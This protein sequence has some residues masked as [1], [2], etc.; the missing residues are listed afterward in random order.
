[1]Q[2]NGAHVLGRDP[3]REPQPGASLKARLA[4]AW[5][6]GEFA[7][8]YATID[9]EFRPMANQIL[10]REFELNDHD[11]EDCMHEALQGLVEMQD[12]GRRGSIPD[13][14]N[15]LFACIRNA[16]RDLLGERTKERAA[17][18]GRMRE[19]GEQLRRRSERGPPQSDEPEQATEAD[20]GPEVIDLRQEEALLLAEAILDPDVAVGPAWA[21]RVVGEAVGRLTPSR[22]RVV[23]HV[24]RWDPDYNSS[25]AP[26]DLGMKPA[27]FRSTKDR[28]Y[29]DL[30][31]LIP[32]VMQEM[33]IEVARLGLPDMFASAPGMFPTNDEDSTP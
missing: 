16:A 21:R 7:V 28:A 27:T 18:D 33:G 22:R 24:L 29:G 11:R 6:N 20:D 2:G 31:L 32:W 10:R 4:S 13:P 12:N 15:Y 30:K 19:R 1:M 14:Y 26:D 5:A 25:N 9:A 3:N 23:L 17:I 8:F